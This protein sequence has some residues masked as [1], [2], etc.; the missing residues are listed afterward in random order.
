[1]HRWAKREWFDNEAKQ[2]ATIAE[3]MHERAERLEKKLENM[4]WA[5][6]GCCGDKVPEH[7]LNEFNG[8]KVCGNC[9]EGLAE[10]L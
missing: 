4:K 5:V 2:A 9:L 1:M 8:D 7:T 3:R 6:C 10:T